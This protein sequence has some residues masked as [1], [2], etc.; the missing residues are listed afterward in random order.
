MFRGVNKE[1]THSW[2][3]KQGIYACWGGGVNKEYT[4][5]WGVNKARNIRMFGAGV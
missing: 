3:C 4:H 1:Y 2:G 5:V